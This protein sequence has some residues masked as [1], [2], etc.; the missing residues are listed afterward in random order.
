MHADRGRR[1]VYVTGVPTHDL[2]D[3]M[4]IVHEAGSSVEEAL[5]RRGGRIHPATRVFQ[6]LRMA[7]NREVPLLRDTLL[8]AE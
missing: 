3:G 1:V 5:G 8:P 4:R 6:G 7:V 2:A